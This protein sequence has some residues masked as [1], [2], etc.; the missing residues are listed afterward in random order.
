[1]PCADQKELFLK[2]NSK[3]DEDN[4]IIDIPKEDEIKIQESIEKDDEIIMKLKELTKEEVFDPKDKEKANLESYLQSQKRKWIS[5]IP[6]V[7]EFYNAG[8]SYPNNKFIL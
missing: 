3:V 5:T 7:L 1:M 4:Y 2:R 8:M 6:T